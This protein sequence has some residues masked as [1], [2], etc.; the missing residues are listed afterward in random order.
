MEKE[1]QWDAGP[2]VLDGPR[3]H[4]A[5]GQKGSMKRGGGHRPPLP[6]LPDPQASQ[7]SGVWECRS[8]VADPV[9]LWTC[10]GL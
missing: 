3:P 1:P 2:Q 8:G 4:I 6:D 9:L 5:Q 10:C 7:P